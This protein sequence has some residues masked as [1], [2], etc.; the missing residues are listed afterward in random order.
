MTG[1][2]GPDDFYRLLAE[3]ARLAGGARRLRDCRAGDCPSGGVYFFF[4]DG[5]V[6]SDG[7]SRVVRVGTHALTL[8]ARQ[9]CGT[10]SGSTAG[11]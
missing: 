8:P 6:R 4:E 1:R 9:P 5:E 10:G 3:L 11:T 2:T 7:S